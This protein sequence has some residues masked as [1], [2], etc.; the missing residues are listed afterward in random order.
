[1]LDFGVNLAFN[2]KVKVGKWYIVLKKILQTLEQSNSPIFLLQT[3]QK[4]KKT[5]Q[6]NIY[7]ILYK[8]L[9]FLNFNKIFTY[10][11]ERVY[12]IRLDAIQWPVV[13]YEHVLLLFLAG[14][15][16]HARVARVVTTISAAVIV[17]IIVFLLKVPSLKPRFRVQL[18]RL[19][20]FVL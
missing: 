14:L 8:L 11:Q 4:K 2:V 18:R 3:E 15:T 7:K 16:C 17:H 20:H 12:E 1:M 6:P 13:Y 5:I 9:L 19:A 10:R